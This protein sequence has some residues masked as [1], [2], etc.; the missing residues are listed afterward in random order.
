[1]TEGLI[2][3]GTTEMTDSFRMTGGTDSAVKDLLGRTEAQLGKAA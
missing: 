1:M 2:E 3:G